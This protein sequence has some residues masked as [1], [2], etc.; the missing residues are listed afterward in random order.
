MHHQTCDMFSSVFICVVFNFVVLALRSHE[1]FSRNIPH[2]LRC[3]S[4]Y[5]LN[6]MPIWSHSLSHNSIK[7]LLFILK[8]SFRYSTMVLLFK[9]FVHQMF[10]LPAWS[11]PY[12]LLL[13]WRSSIKPVYKRHSNRFFDSLNACYCYINI[14]FKTKVASRKTKF[15]TNKNNIIFAILNF[16]R[17]RVFPCSHDNKTAKRHS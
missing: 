12:R 13:L 5:Q 16:Q 14:E 1:A 8:F 17:F 11:T 10:V 6:V 4:H 3:S 15:P 2:G 9:M 7:C